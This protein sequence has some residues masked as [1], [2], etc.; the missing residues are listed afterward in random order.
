MVGFADIP[1]PSEIWILCAVPVIVL[2]AIVPAE[3]LEINPVVVN[4]ATAI[5]SLSYG[6][7]D[8]PSTV[9]SR[10]YAARV[11]GFEAFVILPLAST[12]TLVYVPVGVAVPS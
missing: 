7:A 8:D 5:R 12:T 2:V 3:V 4:P 6:W 10:P 9:P 1:P 11:V